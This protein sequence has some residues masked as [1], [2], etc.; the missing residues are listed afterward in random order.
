MPENTLLITVTASVVL[1]KDHKIMLVQEDKIK[2]RNLWNLPGGRFELHESVKDCAIRECLEETGYN[3]QLTALLGL[4]KYVSGGK[5]DL[6]RYV[7]LAEIIGEQTS[8]WTHE[9][10]AHHWA[11]LQEMDE[12]KDAEW[13]APNCIRAIIK[14]LRSGNK[15]PLDV[16]KWC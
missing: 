10:K 12:I 11:T 14:D 15:F 4:Y 16:V 6:I 9:I 3:V 5:Y 2:N 7:F 13:L 8:Y 1:M